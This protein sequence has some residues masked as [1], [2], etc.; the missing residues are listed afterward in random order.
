MPRIALIHATPLAI[1]PID[2][3][4]RRLWPA[5]HRTN[6]LD[7][8]LSADRAAAGALTPAMIERFIALADYSVATGAD[9]ILFT[10]S[11]FGPAIEAAR[12]AVRVPVLKPNEAMLVE[13][14]AAT[15]GGRGMLGLLATFPA[16]IDSMRDELAAL[17]AAHALTIS[18]VS[19]CVPG[20]MAALDAGDGARHDDLIAAALEAWPAWRDCDAIMLAQFSMARARDRMARKSGKPV[21]ASPDSAVLAMRHALESAPPR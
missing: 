20:A 12:A 5:A 2:D 15:K 6:L 18:V 11:A 13:A 10:C 14:L 17:A 19:H 8:S 3:A 1:A 7:D 21:L 9:G 4:F 16:S